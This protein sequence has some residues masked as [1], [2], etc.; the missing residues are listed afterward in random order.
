MRILSASLLGLSALL[1]QPALAVDYPTQPIKIVV[2]FTPGTGMDNIARILAEKLHPKY[3]QAIVVENRTG[4]S[5]HLGAEQVGR[6]A[7]DGHTLLMTASNLSITA[8]LFA[9]PT[10][11][12][13]TDL[14]PVGIAAV[15]HSS[16]AVNPDKGYKSIHDLVEAAKANPGKIAFASAGV[17]SPAHLHLAQFEED[18]G[19]K[20]MHVPYKGTAPGVNDLVGG[21]VDA[22]FVATHTLKPHVDAG[23]LKN[24]GVGANERSPKAPDVPT[25]AEQ[26]FKSNSRGGARGAWYGMLAPAGT[27][28]EIIQKINADMREV[29]ADPAVKAQLEA[30]GLLIQPTSPEEMKSWIQ[31]EYEGYKQVIQKH[32]IT[33]N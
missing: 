19:V 15:G 2:P 13:M 26:G 3:G 14:T 10:F 20:F 7:P 33:A 8:T 1:A 17:G 12:A 30:T 16:L 32:G 31:D 18:A 24:F 4:V 27:P 25:L 28:D 22:M 29:L 23:R 5:G 21:H 6:A 9:S 11:N